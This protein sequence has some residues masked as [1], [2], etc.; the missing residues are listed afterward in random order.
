MGPEF[1]LALFLGQEGRKRRAL[2]AF[3]LHPHL[4]EFD[5]RLTLHLS[6]REYDC[7]WQKLPH[8]IPEGKISCL[9]LLRTFLGA[10]WGLNYLRRAIFVS[11]RPQK[12][13][14]VLRSN[15]EFCTNYFT[16]SN[17]EG[18]ISIGKVNCDDKAS[19]WSHCEFE[20]WS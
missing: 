17:V 18:D 6:N 9:G 10:R 4:R 8:F 12:M 3:I 11:L 14:N 7:V 13:G 15:K 19:N 16:Q 2:A 20:P 5:C 1:I